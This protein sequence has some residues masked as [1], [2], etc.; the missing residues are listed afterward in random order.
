MGM[1]H[2]ESLLHDTS[3]SLHYACQY[4][5]ADTAQMLLDRGADLNA[6]DAQGRTPMH[7][8]CTKGVGNLRLVVTL[9]NARTWLADLHLARPPCNLDIRDNQ[10]CAPL[11]RASMAGF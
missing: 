8:A 5:E 11:H 7:I 2:L 6:L 1:A 3:S 10:G 4:G 9:L